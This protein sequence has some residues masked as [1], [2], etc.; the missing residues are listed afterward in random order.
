MIHLALLVGQ[1]SC[2]VPRSL[3]HHEGWLYLNVTGLP[4]L[5]E[6]EL[7]QR[8]LQTGALAYVEGETGAGDL[9]A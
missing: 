4:G 6:E 5:V 9:N 8:A 7:Y 1:L 2:A 3:V